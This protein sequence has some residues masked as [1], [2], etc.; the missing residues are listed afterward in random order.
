MLLGIKSNLNFC[1]QLF[2]VY[3]FLSFLADHTQSIE[4][5][6]N[7]SNNAGKGLFLG[8]NNRHFFLNNTG[9]CNLLPGLDWKS[10]VL[11]NTKPNN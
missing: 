9:T 6:D 10:H 3:K 2:R 4:K 11:H 5:L 7:G 8:Q 1:Y